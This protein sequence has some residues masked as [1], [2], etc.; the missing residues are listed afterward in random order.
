MDNEGTPEVMEKHNFS[1]GFLEAPTVRMC[2]SHSS[3]S[4][5]HCP[6]PERPGGPSCTETDFKQSNSK[7]AI[8]TPAKEPFFMQF[9]SFFSHS[10]PFFVEQ[11]ILGECFEM[12]RPESGLKDLDREQAECRNKLDG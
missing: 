8:P 12:S 3:F 11:P 1:R 5:L 7:E 6:H 9:M 10:T 4:G 2:D